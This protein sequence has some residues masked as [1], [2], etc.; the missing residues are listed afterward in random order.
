M[1]LV[2]VAEAGCSGSLS[3][4]NSSMRLRIV[5]KSSAA[6][7]CGIKPSETPHYHASVRFA[8][9]LIPVSLAREQSM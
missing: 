1:M 2:P 5:S 8:N 3:C 4:R 7:G 6:R 9:R